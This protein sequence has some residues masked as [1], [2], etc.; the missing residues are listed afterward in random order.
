MHLPRTADFGFAIRPPDE[1]PVTR[2]GTLDFMAPEVAGS[3]L[4]PTGHIVPHSLRPRYS[5]AA[6]VW[7]FGIMVYE[8]LHMETPF[9]K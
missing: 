8:L 6:D 7:S 3:G 1:R 2:L 4:H 5:Y 9:G